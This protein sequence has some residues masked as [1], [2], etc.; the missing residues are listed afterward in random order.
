VQVE[1]VRL[2]RERTQNSSLGR[3]GVAVVWV[4]ARPRDEELVGIRTGLQ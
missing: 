2:G 1:V 3:V 4:T